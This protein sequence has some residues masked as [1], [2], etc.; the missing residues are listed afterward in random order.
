MYVSLCRH[1]SIDRRVCF[2]IVSFVCFF[3]RAADFAGGKAHNGISQSALRVWRG[4]QEQVEKQLKEHSDYKLVLTGACVCTVLRDALWRIS[5][6]ATL[7]LRKVKRSSSISGST[8]ATN[9]LKL[10]QVSL[11]AFF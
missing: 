8:A 5:S 3:L 6:D 10:V 11:N 7:S 1:H 4:V 2:C 9:D